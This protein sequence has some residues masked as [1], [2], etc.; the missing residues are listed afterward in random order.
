MEE[1]AGIVI[2][3]AS[4]SRDVVV[5][6]VDEVEWCWRRARVMALLDGRKVVV[7]REG[8]LATKA[9]TEGDWVAPRQ[10][11]RQIMA[12]VLEMPAMSFIVVL[13]LIGISSRGFRTSIS[14]MPLKRQKRM[15]Y[16]D[17][18]IIRPC[19]KRRGKPL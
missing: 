5:V 9:E 7:V 15:A 12:V 2:L 17:E 8:A 4:A 3:M 18:K 1:R 13:V 10:E 11:R 6:V 19:N 16:V 14:R